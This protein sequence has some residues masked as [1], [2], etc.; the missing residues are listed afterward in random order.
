MND[1]ETELAAKQIQRE[2]ELNDRAYKKWKRE[3][4][5]Q[6]KKS[7]GSN[8]PYARKFKHMYFDEIVKGLQSEIDEPTR[9]RSS[10]ATAVIK[11]CL[12]LNLTYKKNKY[13]GE[14]EIQP[15]DERSNYFDLDLAVF[16]AL[17]II[18]DNAMSP[19]MKEKMVDKKTGQEKVVYPAVDR[20]NLI[21]KIAKRVE[22][23]IY[24]KYV[25][26]CF[27]EYFA[28]IDKFC[29]GGDDRP[30]SSSFYWRYNM[31]RALK[32][33]GEELRKEG[34][35]TEAE[36]MEWKPF[37]ADRKHIGSWLLSGCL[38]YGSDLFEEHTKQIE[39]NQ[40][41]VYV[42]LT[43]AAERWKD[44][45]IAQQK[46]WCFDDLP[47]LCVPVEATNEHFGSWILSADLLKPQ[48]HKGELRT[49]PLYLEYINRLQSVPYKVNPFITQLLSYLYNR[50]LKLG[51]FV[52]HIYQKPIDLAQAIGVVR[53]GDYEQEGKELRA[54]EEEFRQAKKN[55]SNEHARQLM[56]VEKGRRSRQVYNIL[57]D[58]Q[59]LDR[60]YY[61]HMWDFRGRAYCLCKTSPEPQGTDYQKAAIMFAEP[62]PIDEHTKFW[63]C[64]E[65]ANN[66][67]KDKVSFGE[68]VEWVIQNIED[69]KMIA[70]MFE[71]DNE[72]QALSYLEGIDKPFQ[73]AAACEEF[74]RIFITRER[75]TTTIRCGVDMSCS[76]AGIHAG[77][78]LDAA[79]AEAVNITPSNTPQDLYLRVWNRLLEVN[80]SYP[81]PPI[82]TTLLDEWTKLGYGRNVAKKMIMVFQYSAGLRKQMSEFYKIH[83]EIDESLQMNRDEI[84]SL[85]KLWEQTT[86]SSMSVDSV[87][88]WFQDR[89]KEIYDMGKKEVLI[90]NA[91]GAVQVMK[92]PEY[93]RPREVRSFH[94]GRFTERKPTGKPDLRAWKRAI[95]A[96]ATHMTD[97]AIMVI[98]LH[99]FE[100][101]FSTIHDAAHT[102][103]TGAMNTMLDRLK[104]GYIQAV[105]MDIWDRFRELNGLPIEP[106]TDFP[107]SNTLDLEVVRDSQY[108]FA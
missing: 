61:P 96:N 31:M 48:E 58:L 45:Y 75:T 54:K 55:W 52:P 40:K 23:Q 42:V 101:S 28:D 60:F 33:K 12:G 98:A 89:V 79:D 56:K 44:H 104:E 78:K 51:K 7:D 91:A 32:R 30:R 102:Y 5:E 2:Q 74:Y 34:R 9:I 82:R 66:A 14:K 93:E 64:V 90:P 1:R 13:T 37:G 35:I 3:L 15:S 18:L 25:E 63:L 88:G 49:S 27:P 99:D 95:T 4:E 38:K 50:N 17:Q 20:S 94:N 83:D 97:S 69:I 71:K 105:G 39:G 72:Q 68:R 10:H 29:S 24:F 76:A 47:M 53:R 41:A 67:G 81:V 85:W 86:Q 43:D 87:I 106:A 11:R 62:Q 77:W 103:A 92:Y 8:T 107:K 6:E 21:D 26:K 108:I 80:R 73:F 36:A 59:K 22:Q 19:P 100:Y 16:V 57:N 65:I 84:K 70:T 46:K